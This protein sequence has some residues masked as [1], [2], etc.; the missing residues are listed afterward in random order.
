MGLGKL[1]IYH[2]K[3]DD[4]ELDLET[5]PTIAKILFGIFI[6]VIFTVLIYL[7]I[8]TSP[9]DT[10]LPAQ[11]Q[12]ICTYP[13]NYTGYRATEVQKEAC[14]SYGGRYVWEDS[15][16]KTCDQLEIADSDIPIQECEMHGEE[17]TAQLC[18]DKYNHC[19]NYICRLCNRE[20]LV[21][22]TAKD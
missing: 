1:E 8:T 2:R 16:T 14:Y 20:T 10:P 21:T 11:D 13:D 18:V 5:A 4:E 22:I 3:E 6:G 15:L 12:R 17:A 19:A 9:H 7:I